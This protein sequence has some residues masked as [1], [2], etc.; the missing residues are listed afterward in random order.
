[1]NLRELTSESQTLCHEGF[2]ESEVYVSVLDAVYR[3]DKIQAYN[4]VNGGTFFVINTKPLTKE[5]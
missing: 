1:M 2:S 3:I 4:E 5:N